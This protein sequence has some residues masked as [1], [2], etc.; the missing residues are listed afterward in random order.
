MAPIYVKRTEIMDKFLGWSTSELSNI[1][2]GP[3]GIN[4]CIWNQNNFHCFCCGNPKSN[5]WSVRDNFNDNPDLNKLDD[6]VKFRYRLNDK[7][8]T[9]M[10]PVFETVGR[11]PVMKKTMKNKFVCK[12]MANDYEIARGYGSSKYE[13]KQIAID[14]AIRF[15]KAFL[16]TIDIYYD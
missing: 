1:K 14:N 10:I 4:K 15:T 5:K 12:L 6:H 13:A 9:T 16:G 7:I 3:P 8:V 11:S 2:N